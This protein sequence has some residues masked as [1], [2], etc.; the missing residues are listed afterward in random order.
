LNR[1]NEN[2]IPNVKQNTI[3]NSDDKFE[4]I[5]DNND[6]IPKNKYKMIKINIKETSKISPLFLLGFI[7]L[8]SS[9][10]F[11]SKIIN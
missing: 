9:V 1:L 2:D 11:M 5:N 3:S 10:V 4:K 6:L 8:I 7:A